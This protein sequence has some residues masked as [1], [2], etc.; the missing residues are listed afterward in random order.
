MK[1]ADARK[2]HYRKLAKANNYR[3]RSVYKLSQLNNS[4]HFIKQGMRIVDI[5]AAPGGWLQIASKIIGP[6]GKIIGIDIKE[7]DPI[8]NVITIT[9]NI[10]DDATVNILYKTLSGRADLIL[11][12]VAPNVSGLWEIDHIRQINLTKK[13]TEITT[14]I[15]KRN[16]NALYKVFQGEL[17]EEFIKYC[18]EIFYNVI[19]T[20]PD[21][22]RKQSSEIYLFCKGFLDVKENKDA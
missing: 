19:I 15:L 4:Y 20:K 16:G 14:K 22:S 7:I 1:L 6:S 10:E 17:T 13:A 8:Q 12:D 9:G 11:S 2:D 3:S 5:G 21:A 18:K